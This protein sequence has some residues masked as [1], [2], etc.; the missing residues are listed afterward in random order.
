MPFPF[1]PLQEKRKGFWRIRISANGRIVFRLAAGD[2]SDT[3]RIDPHVPE[4]T[5]VAMQ[6]PPHPGRSIRENG[7]HPLGLHVT[8]AAR[9]LGVARH[10][11]SRVRHGHAAISPEMAIRL[12]K[13]RGPHAEFWRRRQTPCNLVQA[14]RWEHQIQVGRFPSRST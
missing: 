2:G 5:M 3:D 12:E 10:T 13:A 8:E 7:L 9:M 6:N 4:T 14:R 11:L 1:H